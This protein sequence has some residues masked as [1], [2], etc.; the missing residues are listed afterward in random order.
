MHELTWSQAYRVAASVP[1]LPVREAR[2]AESAGALLARPLTALIDLPPFNTAAMDGYAV[3]GRSPWVLRESDALVAGGAPVA[4]LSDGSAVRIST[5]A[6]MPE[7]ATAVLRHE[8]AHIERSSHGTV[9]YAIDSL[10]GLAAS[11]IALGEG[12]DV[13]PQGEECR[14]GDLLLEAG[15]ALTAAGI[16]LAAAAGYDELHV[17]PPPAV[18]LLTTGDELLDRGLPRAGRVRDALG[19]L[20]PA[21]VAA[22]GARALPPIRVPDTRDALLGEI[23]DA[24]GDLIITTGSTA[25]GDR[26]HLREVLLDLQAHWLVDGVAVRPGH[27][28]VLARLRD[29]RFVVGLPGNPLAAVAGLVTLAEPL[30][31]ALRGFEPAEP[32]QATLRA[33]VTSHPE[34]TRL[35]PVRLHEGAGGQ[36]VAEVLKYDGPAMLRSISVADGLAVIAPGAGATG[37][38]C[39]VLPLP[40]H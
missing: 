21:W 31:A 1:P 25:R 32:S 15:S 4:A 20:V 23:E 24:A 10:T 7:G 5:G 3:A 6:P 40:V 18:S 34:D 8:R 2:V 28:M 9:L 27:P 39:P 29:G 36:A 14:A 12:T 19:P 16:G 26:D 13:R 38:T 33:E 17:V 11:D 30:I 37:S 22:C 35:V